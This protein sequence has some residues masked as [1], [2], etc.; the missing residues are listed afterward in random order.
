MS[1]PLPVLEERRR[2]RR[3]GL[4]SK[5]HLVL[6][7]F[8]TGVECH[9]QNISSRGAMVELS[10]PVP[11]QSAYMLFITGADDYLATRTVWQDDRNVGLEFKPAGNRS[12]GP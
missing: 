11:V 5:G 12:A 8:E 10:E 2:D 9:I 4:E 1:L 7:A 3:F 6:S